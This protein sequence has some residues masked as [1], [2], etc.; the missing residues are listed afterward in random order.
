MIATLRRSAAEDPLTG[1]GNRLA[2]ADTLRTWVGASG[3]T[4]AVALLDVDGFKAVNDT[5]GHLEGDRVLIELADALRDAV[6]PE[7]GVFR[8]GG[9]EFAVVLPGTSEAEA[10]LI[11]DRLRMAS[12]MVLASRDAAISV[13]VAAVTATQTVDATLHLAD[14]RLYEAKGR[15]VF[16]PPISL[17]RR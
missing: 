10:V 2:F 15:R 6:R 11:A 5:F 12:G 13:G 8:L 7:D 16:W 14:Q 4:G 1:L 9:D 17:A 3:E